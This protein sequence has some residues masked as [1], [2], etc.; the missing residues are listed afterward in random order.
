MFPNSIRQDD[1]SDEH[2]SSRKNRI[3]GSK[4]SKERENT[5]EW[6]PIVR[7]PTLTNE[8]GAALARL[9]SSHLQRELR[10]SKL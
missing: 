6:V 4:E 10:N 8:K 7:E 3:D 9:I 2:H 5:R 1:S